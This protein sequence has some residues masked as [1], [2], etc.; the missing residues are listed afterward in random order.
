M[1]IDCAGVPDSVASLGAK[2]QPIARDWHPQHCA[3]QR[4]SHG[5]RSK[6][7]EAAVL[8]LFLGEPSNPAI[9]FVR[10]SDQLHVH[11]GQ[12]AFPGGSIEKTDSSITQAALR[13]AYEEAGVEPESVAVLGMLP[14]G[15]VVRSKFR[16]SSLVGWWLSPGELCTH[17]RREIASIHVIE[18]SRLLAK[19]NRVTWVHPL[20]HTG[21]GFTVDGL[22]IWGFTAGVLDRLFELAGW[23]QPWDKSRLSEI[24]TEFFREG[25]FSTGRPAEG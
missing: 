4:P 19:K 24:P 22:F 3:M 23:T 15:R 14:P 2:L 9:V 7:R 20:G 21:P 13:E 25:D 18:V 6:E 8:V 10:K 11:S 1:R 12:V 16:V 17:D 5:E